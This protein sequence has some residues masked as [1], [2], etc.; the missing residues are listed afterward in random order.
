[1]KLQFTLINLLRSMAFFAAACFMVVLPSAHPEGLGTAILYFP[2]AIG[3]GIGSLFGKPAY[4][5]FCGFV[6][7]VAATICAIV[8]LFLVSLWY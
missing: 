3:G 2:V 7:D 5:V 1:M 4:G 8:L 6:F